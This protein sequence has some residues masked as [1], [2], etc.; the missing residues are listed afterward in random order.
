VSGVKIGHPF[1][2]NLQNESINCTCNSD[3]SVAE[4][5]KK[6][7]NSLCSY[8]NPYLANVENRVSS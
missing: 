1:E 5:E 3:H 4:K 2:K 6:Y 8:I 7:C